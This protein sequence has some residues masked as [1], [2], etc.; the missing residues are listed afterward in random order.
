MTHLPFTEMATF[1]NLVCNRH[2]VA[3]YHL[4]IEVEYDFE[5]I[6][7]SSHEKDYRLAW[8]LNRNMGWR[9]SRKEDLELKRDHSISYFAQFQYVLPF[10]KT[11]FTL[12]D[13][14]TEDGLLIT[15]LAQF[16]YL[17]KAEN[18]PWE[19]DDLF[20]RQLKKTPFLIAAFPL[21]LE[22]L[23]NKHLLMV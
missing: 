10:E 1:A 9:L 5:L 7:L 21:Q 2:Q 13:N 20:F 17:L 11:I 16:D 22:K 23:K 8:A 6:G 18:A 14:K 19:L 12:I 15:E 4:D 3:I